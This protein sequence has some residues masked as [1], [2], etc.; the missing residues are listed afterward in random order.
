[1]TRTTVPTRDTAPEASHASLDRVQ[2]TLG[3]TPN[4]QRLMAKSPHVLNGWAA[5]QTSL[6]KTLDVKTRDAISLAVADLNGCHYCNAAHSWIAYNLAKIPPS[7]IA[8]NRRGE[9]A[10]PKR[11]AAAFFAQKLME[12]RG[13]VV[14]SDLAALRSVGYTDANILEIIALTS[15]F[16]MTN[17]INN[18]FDTDVDFQE[19]PAQDEARPASA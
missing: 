11:A 3:F 2:K 5:L 18:A 9:S 17:L 10:D 7:E 12:A 14:E 8:R 6:A 1:M 16:M 4:L 13:K 19:I 15:Q